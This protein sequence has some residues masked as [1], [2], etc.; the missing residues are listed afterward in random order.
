MQRQDEHVEAPREEAEQLPDRDA[1]AVMQR[2]PGDVPRGQ[3]HA[4]AREQRHAAA[5]AHERDHRG[6]DQAAG[7]APAE[8]RDERERRD[9]RADAPE[10]VEPVLLAVR[11]AAR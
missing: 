5:D 10:D 11:R 1:P 4:D 8:A 9:E 3:A 7:D 2:R 6:R